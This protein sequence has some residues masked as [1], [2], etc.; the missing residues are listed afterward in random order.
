[1]TRLARLLGALTG[2]R[3]WAAAAALGAT[4]VLALPPIYGLPALFIAFT[5]LV[6]LIDGVKPVARAWCRVLALGWWFGF[7][8]FVPGLYWITNA[9]LVDAATHG[10]LA[11]FAVAGLSVYFA[12]YP[13]LACLLASWAP[14]GGWRILALA[15]AWAAMEWARGTV[16]TGFPWNLVSTALAFDPTAI[17][18]ASVLGAYGL[19]LVVVVIAA[20]PALL[21]RNRHGHPATVPFV[22]AMAVAVLLIGGGLARVSQA[23]PPGTHAS[24]IHLRLVQGNIPQS[25]KWRQDLMRRHFQLYMDLSRGQGGRPPDVVIWPETAI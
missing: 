17:Q 4:A 6:W 21:A 10:W 16:L 23:P 11:P 15:A 8:F 3:R 13:A 5:G 25:I 2:W 14:P 9:L 12:L 1:M 7:G 19:S 20:A 24:D 18:G 22:A